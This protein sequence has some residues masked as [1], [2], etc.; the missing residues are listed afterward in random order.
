MRVKRYGEFL[1]ENILL[2]DDNLKAELQRLGVEGEE[3]AKQVRL[4]KRGHLADYLNSKGRSF[5]FGI[6][7]AIFLDAREAK[8]YGID[9]KGRKE[10]ANIIRRADYGV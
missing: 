2:K 9:E 7:R 8:R 1:S 3:L 5:T 10:L 6:L 4:A